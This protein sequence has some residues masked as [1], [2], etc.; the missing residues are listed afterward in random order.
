MILVGIDP[1]T[2]KSGVAWINTERQSVHGAVLANG[3]VIDSIYGIG[4]SPDVVGVE[5]YQSYGGKHGF[6]RTSIATIEWTGRFLLSIERRETPIERYSR[7]TIKAH[8]LRSASGNDVQVR[9]AL[10]ARFG[11]DRVIQ[12]GGILAGISTHAWAA[13]AIAVVMAEKRDPAI[14]YLWRKWG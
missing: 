5:Q 4:E 13:L 9:A 3:L 2:E 1:G 8:L 11:G 7:P 12:K 10:V 14:G 6:G